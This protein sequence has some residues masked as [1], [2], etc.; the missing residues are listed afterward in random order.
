M[1]PYLTPWNNKSEKRQQAYYR[2][3]TV[4]ANQT[5]L[6]RSKRDD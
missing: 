5:N 4:K 1:K 6:N 2:L 3:F